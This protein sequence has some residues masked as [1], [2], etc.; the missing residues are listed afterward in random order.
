MSD[1]VNGTAASVAANSI[2][3]SKEAPPMSPSNA[4]PSGGLIAANGGS[5]L[6]AKTGFWALTVGSIGVVYGDIGTSP[7]YAL[8]ESVLAAVGPGN[9]ASEPVV[10]GILSLIIWA[11]LVVVTAKYVLILLRADNNGE[12]G[13]LA[14]MA[15]ASRS[16]GGSSGIV[17][18]LG[19]ISGALFYG[20]AIITPA[21]SVLSAIEG[22][23]IVTPAFD[24]YVVPITVVILIG[25]FAAQSRGTAKVAALFGPITLIWFAAIAAAGLWHI[26][27]NLTVLLAFNP[28]YGVNFLAHH[29]IIGFYTLGA[30][31]LVVTGSEALYA[32]LGHFGRGPIRFAWLVVVLPALL[33]NYLGQGALVLANPKTIENPFFLLFPEWALLPMV[34]LA[35]AATVIASQ[36]V[37]TGAYSL[38][39]QAIQLGLLPRLEIRHTSESLFGQIYM[40]RVNT[41]LLIGVLLLVALFRSSSALASAYG[42]A[43]TGTMVVTAMMAIIVIRRVWHWPLVAALALMLPFLFIDLTFLAANLLKVVEGGWMPLALGVLVMS[44]MYTWRRG[45]RLLFEKTRRQETPLESLVRSLEKKPPARVPGTAVFLTSDPASAPT[46]LLHSLKH[47]KV[48]HEKN[49]ILTIETADTPRVSEAERVRIEPVGQTFSRVVLRF[50]FMETPNVPKALAIARKL[51]WQF[52]IMSTSFFL[53]R[54]TLKPAPHSG[55][56][57][58]QDRLFIALTRVANDATDYF[59]IPTGRVVEVG[60]QV[61]V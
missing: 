13:T 26:G 6:P 18:L 54:R 49:V 36:A 20:D 21:L 50:G 41:L 14:L 25:L 3:F 32:D 10:L 45:S 17:I 4:A 44:V 11:L 30:V 46:A 27:Q 24:S 12:G 61:T 57:R 35:T 23:K 34:I 1:G 51:G 29:G 58:W 22:L 40:P 43:V 2:S 8:R 56:P 55:M 16:L 47:Y 42:I 33:I 60:T 37:I 28:Y 31:F 39:R 52:D 59:Q 48:L 7:L 19:I 38:T 15:L 5:E 53:S 9:A